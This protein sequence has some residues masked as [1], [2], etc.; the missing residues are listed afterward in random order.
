MPTGRYASGFANTLMSKD[1]RL[2]LNAVQGQ[3]G[4]TTIG[5]VTAALWERFGAAEPGADFTC[6]FSF[7]ERF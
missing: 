7:V 1:V 2:Y 4:P 5:T 3:D 6:V